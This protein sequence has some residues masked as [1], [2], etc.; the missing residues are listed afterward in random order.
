MAMKCATELFEIIQN[1]CELEP[2]NTQGFGNLK[3]QGMKF[4]IKAYRAKGLGHV[5]F[6][7][8]RGLFGLMQMDTIIVTPLEKD[9]PLFSYDRIKAF[10]N[11]TLI[12]EL[13]DT[14]VSTE[15]L[16]VVDEL[17]TLISNYKDLPYRDPGKHW[18]DDIKL[19]GGMSYKG[20]KKESET[21]DKLSKEY[22]TK[23]FNLPDVP[24]TDVA[25]KK[26]KTLNY[27][28]DLIEN[29]GPSTN[30]FIKAIG[31]EKTK[32]LFYQVLFGV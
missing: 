31:K 27:V 12:G 20:K 3:I 13:F 26:Q 7:S 11:D 9:L 23:F 5:S 15:S 1:K 24:V 14:V 30:V 21:F 4:D 2:I 18:Y 28:N 8:A 32:K 16:D 29:G 22:M 10:G 25:V 6:M 19:S 17:E